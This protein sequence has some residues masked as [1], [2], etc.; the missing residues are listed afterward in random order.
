MLLRTILQLSLAPPGSNTAQWQQV[1]C[2]A[3][4]QAWQ[5]A[6]T[7]LEIHRLQPLFFYALKMHGLVNCLPPFIVNHLFAVYM[8]SLRRNVSFFQSLATALVPMY[9]ADVHPVLWKGV[10]LADQMYPHFATR[11]IG[12]IDWAI[13]PHELNRVSYELKQL[14]FILQENLTTPDAVYFKSSD[15]VVFD[16]HHRVRLFEGKEHLA[17]TLDLDPQT[18]GLPQLRVLEANAMLTHL[19][20]HLEAHLSETGPM[21]FWILDFVFLLRQW[22]HHIEWERLKE[23]MPS[24]QSWLLL[25]RL[26]RFLQT[27]FAEP[28]PPVLAQFAQQH[29]PLVL[30]S[31][32]RQRRLALWGLPRPKGWL[33]LM[34]CRLG[35]QS[36]HKYGYPHLSDL[37]LWATDLISPLSQHRLP[38]ANPKISWDL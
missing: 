15:Q 11:M 32:L 10:V 34:A 8:F 4:D 31:I 9:E 29:Q 16:V 14:G 23:L 21:L 37:L 5:S 20:V 22:G 25:G 3:T 38:I 12:D 13:A 17:L 18:K 2:D 28:L 24:P 26:L 19:T 30:E 35:M 36:P 7:D 1:F 33:R 27:E 6:M